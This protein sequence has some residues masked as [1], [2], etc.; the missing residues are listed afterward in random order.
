MDPND[1]KILYAGAILG[2]VYKTTDGGQA[3]QAMNTG[4]DISNQE[5]LAIIV[6]DQQDSQHLYFT[7]SGS[8]YETTDGGGSWHEVASE[9]LPHGC[10]VGL[11]VDPS[12]G[13]ILYLA[14]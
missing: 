10:V 14:R 8:L 2:G 13:N 4:I 1:S 11:V 5:W 6:M 3:W 12:D 9:N 7:H